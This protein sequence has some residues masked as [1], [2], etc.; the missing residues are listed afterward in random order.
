MSL[1]RKKKSE[2]TISRFRQPRGGVKSGVEDIFPFEVP[3][4]DTLTPD[5]KQYINQLESQYL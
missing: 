5:T 1:S 2:S 3:N 4:I